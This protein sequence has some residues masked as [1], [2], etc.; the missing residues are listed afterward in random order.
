[1]FGGTGVTILGAGEADAETV[2]A[3][4]RMAPVLVCA[5]G[6]ADTALS[7][8][9]MPDLV[10][11]DMDSL[12]EN[13]ARLIAPG[14]IIG[15][16]EQDTTDFE[17][18]VCSVEALFFI[19]VGVVSPRIDHSLASLNVLV[20]HAGKKIAILTDSDFC[21]LAPPELS[22]ELPPAARL[23]LFPMADAE[24]KSSGL[25]WPIDGLKFSPSGNIA[26]SNETTDRRVFLE[27]AEPSMI[28]ILPAEFAADALPAFL[29]AAVWDRSAA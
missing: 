9:R 10:I 22:L 19:A 20:R 12:S 25:R 4:V 13:A 7:F 18:C 28:V 8:R 17:K 29:D 26:V 21:F 14:R 1:M 23:S 3:A 16:K 27:F 15:I 2:G 11:G 5:D 24:G 6:G